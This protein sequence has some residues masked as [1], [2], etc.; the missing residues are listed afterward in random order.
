AFV[1]ARTLSSPLLALNEAAM[2]IARGDLTARVTVKGTD[3]WGALALSFNQMASSNQEQLWIKSTLA[4][5]SSLM[6]SSESAEHFASVMIRKLA[7]LLGCG[8]GVFYIRTED[9]RSYRLF[10]SYGFQEQKRLNNT[11]A[12]GEG[13]VGQ[14]AMEKEPILL[15]NVPADHIRIATGLGESSPLMVIAVPLIFQ[16]DVLAVVELATHTPFS[17]SQKELLHELMISLGIGLENLNRNQ[18]TIILLQQ[19]QQQAEELEMQSEE[20]R[21]ANEELQSQQTVLEQANQALLTAR[22]EV[23]A[24]AADLAASSRYK[25]QFLAN[26]SHELRTPLNSLLLLAKGFAENEEGNLT[27]SQ[28]ESARIIFDSGTDLLELINDILDLSKIEAGRMDVHLAPVNIREFAEEIRIGFKHMAAAK[29]LSWEVMAPPGPEILVTDRGKVRQILKNFLSNAFKFTEKGGVS[30]TFAPVEKGLS[31]AVTDTGIGIPPDKHKLIFEA[32]Q[33]ADGS[34]SRKYGGTGLGLSIVRELSRLLGGEIQLVSQEGKGSIFSLLLPVQAHGEMR[35]CDLTTLPERT[36]ESYSPPEQLPSP[37]LKAVLE[38]SQAL[39]GSIEHFIEDDRNVIASG[40][41]LLLVIE[42][43]ANFAAIVRNLARQRGFKCLVTDRGASGLLLAARHQPAGII[44]DHSLP[45]MDGKEVMIGLRQNQATSSIPVHIISAMDRQQSLGHGAIGV[46]QK[47]VTREQLQSVMENFECQ[48]KGRRSKL[49]LVDDDIL[50]RISTLRLLESDDIQVIAAANCQEALH[51]L[52]HETFDCMIL[53]LSLP[54]CSGFR[55]LENISKDPM[56][57]ELP[58]VIHSGK[59]LSR[60]EYSQ[61]R[62]YTDAVVTK[63]TPGSADRLVREVGAFLQAMDKAPVP[64][65][66]D[67]SR[68]IHEWKALFA[69][70]SILLVDDDVRN[71]FA[72]SRVLE[73]RGLNVIMAPDGLTALELLEHS[74]RSVDAVLMD[75]MM[76]GLDGN[77]TTRRVREKEKFRHLPIIGLSAKAMADDRQR[78]L[79]AGMD[80]FLSK[81][82]DQDL[83]LSLLRDIL[84]NKVLSHDR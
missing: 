36:Q 25:S 26:M 14:C 47:P 58:V 62:R 48:N 31:I 18:R 52:H 40:D 23:E 55:L 22:A 34:T 82:V 83:L 44:L 77:E 20:M 74:P 59:E 54:D 70:K 28:Q 37:A 80:H 65:T 9:H 57:H 73:K 10:G 43:D 7:S 5:L 69:N 21:Q 30:V 64:E 11:F 16:N 27:P 49:M 53:D 61:L 2:K 24:K 45:D 60:A 46:L 3:E 67:E 32:F 29:G 38:S 35:S 1:F 71:T 33:Q 66:R 41:R 78:S 84:V 79:D 81:P 68:Q 4:E 15:T 8:H 50:S 12:L 75:V 72:L 63:G 76:P 13:L 56:I 17:S 6:Q 51:L 42:D 39:M 19:T